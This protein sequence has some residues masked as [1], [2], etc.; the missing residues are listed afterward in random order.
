VSG[1]ALVS[2]LTI[3]LAV[4]L[5][6]RF[7]VPGRR[8]A[9]VWLTVALGVAAALL[10]SVVIRLLGGDL[11]GLTV[12]RLAVQAGF[13]G[14]AVALAVVTA[15]RQPAPDG[16]APAIRASAAPPPGGVAGEQREREEGP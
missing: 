2:G 4:G 11:A 6:G 5:A 14:V 9:P 8:A 1:S 12:P 13:A 3:G 16:Y 7:L 10:G 15:D